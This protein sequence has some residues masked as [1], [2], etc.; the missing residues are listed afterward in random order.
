MAFLKEMLDREIVL[1]GVG[2]LVLLLYG[3]YTRNGLKIRVPRETICRVIKDISQ[4]LRLLLF[5][6]ALLFIFWAILYIPAQSAVLRRSLGASFSL[7]PVFGDR[8]GYVAALPQGLGW[9]GLNLV[10]L[11]VLWI[12]YRFKV[13]RAYLFGSERAGRGNQTVFAVGAIVLSGAS[14]LMILGPL[15]ASPDVELVK[16]MVLA[17]VVSGF[18]VRAAYLVK[19]WRW[20]ALALLA[21]CVVVFLAIS[22]YM[23]PAFFLVFAITAVWL[24]T[25]IF[26]R[27]Q[28]KGMYLPLLGSFD[29][30]LTYAAAISAL[31]VGGMLRPL[32]N[33]AQDPAFQLMG[34]YLTVAWALPGL[35]TALLFRF[36]GHGRIATLRIA[37]WA[38]LLVVAV[39]YAIFLWTKA[40]IAIS[41]VPLALSAVA[42]VGLLS[43]SLARCM[44]FV[45]PWLMLLAFGLI[46]NAFVRLMPIP[47][48]VA[49]P[50]EAGTPGADKFADYYQSWA[51]THSD[52]GPI[53]LVAAAG[54]G[55]R[56]AQHVADSLAHVDAA[57]NGAFG[58]QI[59]AISGVSGGAL[60]ALI[61]SGARDEKMLD[62]GTNGWNEKSLSTGGELTSFFS[63]DLLSP[64]ANTLVLRDLPLAAIPGVKIA[65]SRDDALEAAWLSA[66][67]DLE[68]RRH[69][70]A[71]GGRFADFFYDEKR[72][73]PSEPLLLFGSTS[74]TSGRLVIRTNLPIGLGSSSSAAKA[75]EVTSDAK[76]ARSAKADADIGVGRVALDP[77]VFA[78]R[79]ALDSAR[80]PLVSAVGSACANVG[81]DLSNEPANVDV[82]CTRVGYTRPVAITDGGYADNSGLAT[83]DI[84]YNRLRELGVD[85]SRI[86]VVYV[87]SNP[88]EG[89]DYNEGTRFDSASLTGTLAAPL[90]LMETARAGRAESIANLVRQR[91]PPNHFV[92]W[93]MSDAR[94]ENGKA[95]A[96]SSVDPKDVATV[97][98]LPPLG[99]TLDS[100]AVT[101]IEQ[102]SLSHARVFA[103]GCSN[104]QPAEL[105][106]C[107]RLKP[108]GI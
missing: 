79:A 104:A 37:A 69:V 17:G 39:L 9:I 61:W 98:S 60:G 48:Q 12:F 102:L 23:G 51:S 67:K 78:V 95:T 59:F 57:T 75:H 88:E 35:L 47:L 56:A 101:S 13:Q 68:R 89:R 11:T 73:W 18:L 94:V 81:I 52:A 2:L 20:F 32:M 15:V 4:S 33:G 24:V 76:A 91:I 34:A 85:P 27:H 10:F 8:A 82:R 86:F 99:W 43:T 16:Y 36:Q 108:P 38:S 42:L 87:T 45:R 40:L 6:A 41:A 30:V 105:E 96:S 25:V 65:A 58:R 100:I 21:I 3:E 55:V 5:P 26:Q 50:P 92:E 29:I 103:Q 83:L 46:G 107:N 14:H 44:K 93:H 71:D 53:I 74:A 97:R 19:R 54:G 72:D 70:N 63:S 1:L 31:I 62:P 28:I 22:G 66:W 7:R 49:T 80:F 64:S 106:L 77:H 90:L 84:V